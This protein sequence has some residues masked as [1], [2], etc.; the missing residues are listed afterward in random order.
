M[1][2][3]IRSPIVGCLAAALAAVLTTTMLAAAAQAANKGVLRI[4]TWNMEWLIAPQDFLG[5]ARTC[6]PKDA[7]PGVR[8]RFIPCNV[9]LEHERS[10]LDL[11]VMTRYA[12]QL[13]ADI[14]ALQEVDGVA[15][16][17]QVFRN[18]DFCFSRREGVQN[19]GFAV[20]KGVPHRCAADVTG[21]SLD[22]RVRRGAQL[23]VYPG[24][25]RE[26]R[27]LSVHLKSGCPR[28]TLDDPKR[29][30][31]TLARQV[32]ELEKWIDEQAAAGHRFAILGD[33]N[34]DLLASQGPARND[35]GQIRNFWS[36]IDD[37][38]PV[39]LKL[40]N[41]AERQPFINCSAEQNY[42]SYIDHVVL[43]S[44]LAEW[45][46]P[47]SFVRVTYETRDALQRKLPD[48][49]PIGVDLR[50]PPT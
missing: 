18:H 6:L 28:R 43:D 40:L 11:Q 42:S 17:K 14:V 19:T 29:D 33:F 34:H 48:H 25:R 16:A 23:I 30:C 15:A 20:R 49:C 4:A 13:D 3:P 46:V 27:L 24:E 1:H 50:V 44:Q 35:T 2:R 8:K 10:A 47:N 21:I 37:G 41:I 36:E 22:D 45:R 38:D 7:S 32:P 26:F 9:A 12:D 5:L 31:E 39:G